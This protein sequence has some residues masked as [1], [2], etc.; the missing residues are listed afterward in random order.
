MSILEKIARWFFICSLPALII[1]ATVHFEFNSLRLYQNGFEKYN[2]GEVTGLDDQELEKVARG[3]ISYFNSSDEL[4]SINVS[5]D[6]ESFGLFNQ[7]EINHLKD[8]KGLVRLNSYLFIGM[9]VYAGIYA[10]ISWH[11]KRNR[12]LLARSLVIGSAITLGIIVALGAGSMLLDFNRLFTQFHFI[13]FTN[14]LWMLD[15]SRD[16]LIM[17]FPQGFWFDAALLLGKIAA[18]AAAGLMAGGILYLKKCKKS[19]PDTASC[20]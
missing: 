2:V 12:R 7:R 11:R 16:Y 3:L 18:G 9:A 15:P 4:I 8:V 13:A 17:L 10:G 6:G 14:D 20:D 5:R 19:G 1:S